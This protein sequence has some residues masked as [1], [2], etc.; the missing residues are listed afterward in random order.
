[1]DAYGHGRLAVRVHPGGPGAVPAEGPPLPRRLRV[2]AQR[3]PVRRRPADHRPGD[4]AQPHRPGRRSRPCATPRCSPTS[5][6]RR[7]RPS[8][9]SSTSSSTCR[10][11][12]SPATAS[13]RTSSTC[14]ARLQHADE[15]AHKSDAQVVLIGILPTLTQAHTVLDN[16][17]ANPR[18]RLLNEQIVGA[19]GE[20]IEL[21]IRGV[22]RLQAYNRLDRARGGLHQRPVPP[23]G[24]AGRVRGATGT[25]RRRSPA[26]RSRS[27]PTRRSCSAGGCGPRPGSP[28]SSRPPTPAR[29]S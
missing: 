5:P 25:P 12:S 19:R 13:P 24:G 4:R 17:S 8:S 10:R 3:L 16:L 14:A 2:D 6:T 1:M 26:S 18:Y 23:A 15:R 21:D 29:T 22:E 28:C 9:A 20:D 27:A 7:S 11:G